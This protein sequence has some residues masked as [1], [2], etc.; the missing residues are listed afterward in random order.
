MKDNETWPIKQLV[1]DVH[2]YLEDGLM[3]FTERYHRTRG[4]CCGSSCR[5]CPF[6]HVNVN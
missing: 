3:V 4:D 2:Y 5:H 1:E 6:N